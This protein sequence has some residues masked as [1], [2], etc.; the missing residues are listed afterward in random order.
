MLM[1]KTL[2]DE[3]LLLKAPYDI[4]DLTLKVLNGLG[5]EYHSLVDA[6][7]A[8]KTY[9]SRRS[10]SPSFWQHHLSYYC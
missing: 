7:K 2:K 3:L 1:F 10:T 6:I 5:H 4:D 9:N 8:R